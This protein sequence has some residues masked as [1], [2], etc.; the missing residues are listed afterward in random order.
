MMDLNVNKWLVVQ[1]CLNTVLLFLTMV[2][3]SMHHARYMPSSFGFLYFLAVLGFAGV[4]VA[5]I[6]DLITAAT[7][8]V[9]GQ[10]VHKQGRTVHIRRIDGKLKKYKVMVPEVVQKLEMG[11][12]VTMSLT[13]L[14][15]I[16]SSITIMESPT[17]HESFLEAQ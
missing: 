8:Q 1:L 2:I 15:H 9:Q 3:F 10:I 11:Q 4:V 5:I 7:R 14:A 16:P 17:D 13:K 6:V 12:F